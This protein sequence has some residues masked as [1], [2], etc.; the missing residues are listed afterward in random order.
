MEVALE[1]SKTLK[2]PLIYR[3]ELANC[4]C[5]TLD[6]KKA[7]EI[8]LPLVEVQRFQVWMEAFN[9]CWFISFYSG[10][11]SL[12]LAI[13]W[14]LCYDGWNWESPSTVSEIGGKNTS[15]T[16]F[17]FLQSTSTKSS[18]DGIVIRQAKVKQTLSFAKFSVQRY[19]NNGGYFAA[20]ELLYL[21]R[22]LAKMTPI[23]K[24]V[25]ENLDSMVLVTKKERSWSI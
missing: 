22:D 11:S 18:L 8:Y 24:K 5:M 10:S 19:L 17:M 25:L 21:R 16:L 13:G 1:N 2:P 4:F 7:A 9:V 6:F 20:F 23:M 12:Y 14:L 3:Y 15:I